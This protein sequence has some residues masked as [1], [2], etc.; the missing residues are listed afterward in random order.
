MDSIRVIVFLDLPGPELKTY[1]KIANANGIWRSLP[2]KIPKVHVIIR[3]SS[4]LMDFTEKV[5]LQLKICGIYGIS[6]F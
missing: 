3:N 2:R 1:I 6:C 5:R 4:I